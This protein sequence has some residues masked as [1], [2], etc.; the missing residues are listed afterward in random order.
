MALYL[1]N[2]FRKTRSNYEENRRRK[3]DKRKNKD[4]YPIALIG[5]DFNVIA[6]AYSKR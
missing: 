5:L 3:Q 6:N 2:I 1:L 4:L